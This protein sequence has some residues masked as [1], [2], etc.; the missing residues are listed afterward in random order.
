MRAVIQQMFWTLFVRVLLVAAGFISSVITAR[1]LGPEGRGVFFYWSTVAAL[2]IQFGNLGLHSSNTYYLA[3]GKATLSM[4]ATNALWFSIIVGIVLGGLLI[5]VLCLSRQTLQGQWS[6]V[7]PTCLMIPAGLYFFFGL[8][9]LVAQGCVIEYNFYEL[10]ARYVGLFLMLFAVWCWGSP[11]SLLFVSSMTTMLVCVSLYCRFK[12]LGQISKPNLQLMREGFSYALPIYLTS[13]FSFLVFRLNILMLQCYLNEM[14]LGIFSIAMQ[15]LEI[16]NIIPTTFVLILF[17]RVLCTERPY[18]MVQR[19][20]CSVAGLLVL[21]WIFIVIFGNDFIRVIYGQSFTGAY[22]ILLY[23]LPGSFC[24]GLITVISQ[25]SMA[26]GRS[27]ALIWIW[28]VGLV[29]E[30]GLSVWLIPGYGMVGAMGA[31]SAA[32]LLVFSLVVCLTYS[33]KNKNQ[34]IA[35]NSGKFNAA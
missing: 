1:F 34:H 18:H 22:K 3:K 10:A 2:A 5:L 23:G 9:L 31:F 11:T 13:V 26:T 24:L 20:M 19:Q 6:L 32:Y 27:F 30:W 8:N 15:L 14:A 25:Y 4:L 21:S 12:K 7:L 29:C 33:F 17:P 35:V 28:L 16:I